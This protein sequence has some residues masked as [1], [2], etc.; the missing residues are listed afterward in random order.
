MSVGNSSVPFAFLLPML[1]PEEAAESKRGAPSLEPLFPCS[2]LSQG[3]EEA[4]GQCLVSPSQAFS[5]PRSLGATGG[6]FAEQRRE[7]QVL[8]SIAEVC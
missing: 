8:V 7:T 2:V 3:G 1:T 4:T 6:T 5:S